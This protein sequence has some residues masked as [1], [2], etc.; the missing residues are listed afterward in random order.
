MYW[1]V[2]SG[3]WIRSLLD[4]ERDYHEETIRLAAEH[5]LNAVQWSVRALMRMEPDRRRQLG[6]RLES[7]NLHA[8]LGLHADWLADP[9]EPG[10][11]V[12]GCL[13][14]I[15]ELPEMMRAPIFT[16]CVGR[17]HRFMREPSL[18][19]QMHRLEAALAPLARAAQEAG[20]PLAIEN[21]GDYYCSDLAALCERVPGLG[22]FLDTGNTMLIGEKPLPAVR[23]AAPFT[24]GTHFK[25]HY[26]RPRF[27]PLGFQ[28][29]GA[30]PGQ[31]DVGLRE[32]FEVL[33]G[34]AP[35]PQNLAMI[36]ELDPV[37]G[38]EPGEVLGEA[39]EFVRSL[40]E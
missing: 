3:G 20:A 16:T 11:R 22:I 29:R 39:V 31:G 36:L 13:E 33:L 5:G 40:E 30:V 2:M 37:E 26:G 14:A 38:M 17:Y 6:G 9:D 15:E 27:R 19:E 4:D 35:D 32:A 24:V 25:D 7:R 8:V 21:H 34:N 1:G 12:E 28:I 10:P 23:D 18:E